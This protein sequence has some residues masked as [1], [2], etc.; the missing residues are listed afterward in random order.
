MDEIREIP[1]VDIPEVEERELPEFEQS[2]SHPGD[3]H[4]RANGETNA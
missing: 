3:D 1:Q 2:T 4:T